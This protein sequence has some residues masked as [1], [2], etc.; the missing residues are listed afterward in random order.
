MLQ[1]IE[2]DRQWQVSGAMTV[3]HVQELLAESESL[4]QKQTLQIDLSLVTDVDTASISLMLEWI[5]RA[6]ARGATLVFVNIPKSLMSL[7][8]LYEVSPLIQH[9][10][11]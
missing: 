7:V 8:K 1:I 11:R 5:R 9:I 6:K 4:Q 2:S 3:A 10:K